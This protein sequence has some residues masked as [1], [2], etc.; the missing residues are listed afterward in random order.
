MFLSYRYRL[1]P[2]RPHLPQ[3]D[4]WRS[5]LTFLWNYALERRRTAWERERRRVSY[6][7]QQR[8]LTRWR[9]FDTEGIGRVLVGVAQGILQ[10]LD[11][12]YTVPDPPPPPSE[13]PRHPVGFDLGL[14]HLATLSDGTVVDS[15]QFPRAAEQRLA[16]EQRVL[17]RTIFMGNGRS[18]AVH[19]FQ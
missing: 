3:L 12:A 15:P 13:A 10:R 11:L 2:L 8:D 18:R 1:Y 9:N 5:E 16:R 17:A 7:D 4:R 19:R 14:T 6:L